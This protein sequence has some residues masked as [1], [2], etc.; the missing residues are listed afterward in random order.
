MKFINNCDQQA[1]KA[2]E[3]LASNP[4]PTGY[5]S[6]FN[7]EHLIQISLELKKSL[8]KTNQSAK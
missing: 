3:Y 5:N 2:L 7:S 1:I 4:K 6:P 8:E